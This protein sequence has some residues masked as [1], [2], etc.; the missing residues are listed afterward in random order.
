MSATEYDRLVELDATWLPG[1]FPG[2][3]L[4]VLQGD[5]GSASLWVTEGT[6]PDPC[7]VALLTPDAIEA[8]AAVLTAGLNDARG[9]SDG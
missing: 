8:L 9:T 3:G 1:L 7:R 2:S 4:H 5:D 6:G